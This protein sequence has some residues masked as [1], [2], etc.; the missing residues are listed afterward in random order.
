MKPKYWNKGKIY[1]S[2]KDKVLKKLI[3]TYRNEYLNLN[4]NYF[5]SLINSIIGQQISV[6][7]ADSMKTKF[8]KLKRNITPQTVSK[9][10]T[11]DLRKCGLSR[12]KILYI[13][14]ISKFFLQNKK[15]IKNIN[16]TSEEEIY[17]NLIEIKGV[18]NWTIHMFLMF[19]Y[20]SSNIFPTGDLGFLK[21]ISK[22]YKVKLPISERKLK[23]LYKKWSPY[24]SQATWY[25]WR[26]LD[27]IPVNY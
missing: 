7:A 26:S 10:R 27:P 19:S 14:N 25:L 1:L 24:S 5:H 17:N 3:Q 21:A 16:K 12:Q 6:S 11:T 4:F 23:L 9:L 8:F 13:R 20:G 2:N 15:F 18:G 22:L